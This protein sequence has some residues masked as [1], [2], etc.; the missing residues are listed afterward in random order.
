MYRMFLVVFVT[1]CVPISA[2][3]PA[4]A[5]DA[6]ERFFTDQ[7]GK[8]R[9][10]ASIVDLNETHVK[11]RKQD[12]TEITLELNK[13][14]DSDQTFLNNAYQQYK[15]MVGDF[16]IGTAVEIFST[17]AWHPGKV[18]NVQPGKYYITFDKYSETWNKWVPVEQLRLSTLPPPNQPSENATAASPRPASPMPKPNPPANDV[19]KGP[20]LESLLAGVVVTDLSAAPLEPVNFSPDPLP[21]FGVALEMPKGFEVP[22]TRVGNPVFADFDPTMKYVAIDPINFGASVHEAFLVSLANPAAKLT[23]RVPDKIIGLD[24]NAESIFF[25]NTSSNDAS[26]Y[27]RLERNSDSSALRMSDAT[28]WLPAPNYPYSET[29]LAQH[30]MLLWHANAVQ[31]RDTN[32]GAVL[33][34]FRGSAKIAASGTGRYFACWD[35]KAAIAMVDT[36]SLKVIQ[37]IPLDWTPSK[38]AFDPS[39]T[40]LAVTA[41][42]RGEVFDLSSGKSIH[43]YGLTS[44]DS[45]EIGIAWLGTNY[46]ILNGGLLID[47]EAG[48]PI[49][50]FTFGRQPLLQ[51]DDQTIGEVS[52]SGTTVSV[53]WFRIASEK[54]Q[55]AFAPDPKAGIS[56]PRDSVASVDVSGLQVATTEVK[57]AIEGNLEYLGY[58][59]G[60]S[61]FL[62]VKISSVSSPPV[63]IQ[64]KDFMKVNRDQFATYT[65]VTVTTEM[66]L[67]SKSIWKISRDYSQ[68]LSRG[69][70]SIGADENAQQVVTRLT[71]PSVSS[72]TL[73]SLPRAG[74]SYQRGGEKDLGKGTLSELNQKVGGTQR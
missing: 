54:I 31:L 70:I 60:Q 67:D 45:G 13:L 23:F 59:L 52:G 28:R 46:L 15:A 10:K 51:Y 9:I 58:K 19:Y 5:Q 3:S 14:S 49:W 42:G 6:K 7:S 40:R 38:I 8:F 11:L 27:Q 34:L 48:R 65:P 39:G 47:L 1:V 18:L 64:M 63:K 33:A 68:N 20:S 12:G 4:F 74:G 26:V 55:A 44:N 21:T 35:S 57:Q 36:R 50:R 29:F 71:T 25:A 16:P 72:M 32:T 56:I 61:G 37:R 66:I 24:D 2:L 69:T 41:T 53:N 30:R 73:L 22:T 43:S 17:G 62:Q